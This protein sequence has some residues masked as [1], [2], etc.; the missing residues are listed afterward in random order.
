MNSRDVSAALLAGLAAI[1]FALWTPALAQEE[2]EPQTRPNPIDSAMMKKPGDDVS[3]LPSPGDVIKK[4]GDDLVGAK[5]IYKPNPV[6][7]T[8]PSAKLHGADKQR[9]GPS[10]KLFGSDGGVGDRGGAGKR[11]KA[12]SVKLEGADK[13]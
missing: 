6:A 9:T 3:K 5:R 8:G 12:P 10:S 1:A 4:G 2:E 13:Q 11:L 7:K